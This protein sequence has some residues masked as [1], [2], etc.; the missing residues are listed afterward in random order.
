MIPFCPRC[1]MQ[2]KVVSAD[3]R[4]KADAYWCQRCDNSF[5]RGEAKTC[6]K[7]EGPVGPGKATRN[8]C[9][10]CDMNYTADEVR[11]LYVEAIPCTCF[12]LM[13]SGDKKMPDLCR[14]HGDRK[15]VP[16][17]TTPR[18]RTDDEQLRYIQGYVAYDV[19][20]DAFAG[21]N[22]YC[23]PDKRKDFYDGWDA[24][25]KD[26]ASGIGKRQFG[27]ASVQCPNCRKEM[28]EDEKGIL[29]CAPCS[30]KALKAV[31]TLLQKK[32]VPHSV[33]VEP[34][35]LWA[36]WAY[37]QF[38]YWVGGEITAV[39]DDG[40]VYAPSYQSWWKPGVIV[41]ATR[42]KE[43]KT[44]LD[45]LTLDRRTAERDF[46]KEWRMKLNDVT[47]GILPRKEK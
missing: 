16:L 15:G 13:G 17:T 32:E 10:K 35:T 23:E 46:A 9:A 6:P 18:K 22:P 47:D 31:A 39:R 36:F 19:R 11:P 41:T 21:A 28:K 27:H 24:A 44:E 29:V 38:P 34:G 45:L 7:C 2:D 3:V 25:A 8:Y 5:H 37:D 30:E 43:L 33:D 12:Y 1:E 42:G 20:V 26:I 14:I 40:R 4:T